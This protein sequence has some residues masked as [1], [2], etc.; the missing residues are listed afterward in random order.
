MAVI[1]DITLSLD[2]FVSGPDDGVEALHRWAV[3]DDRTA[4]DVGLLAALTDATGAVVMGRRTFDVVDGP[5][6]WNEDMHY[7]A[8]Q[9]DVPPPCFVVTHHAP[10]HVRLTDR[11]TIVTTGLRDALD[12]A[13]AAAGDKDVFIMGGG[14]LGGSALHDGLVDR[15]HLHVAPLLLGTGTPLF[16]GSRMNLRL[17]E[18]ATVVTRN[19]A[20]LH[21]D[22]LR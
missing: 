13:T 16:E 3:G 17:D 8:D 15:L 6:G 22:V 5:D 7:G 2:G 1:L 14:E 18:A 10:Q 4:Q 12:Q 9:G 21:Y 11:M 19:A 20:H